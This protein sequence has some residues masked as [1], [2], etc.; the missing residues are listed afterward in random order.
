LVKKT[1]FTHFERWI[2][3]L[4]INFDEKLISNFAETWEI[5][6]IFNLKRY[7]VS[8]TAPSIAFY[9]SLGS[10]FACKETKIQEQ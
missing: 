7:V 9:G 1:K 6:N 8:V 2:T 10:L 4:V 3:K 5:K